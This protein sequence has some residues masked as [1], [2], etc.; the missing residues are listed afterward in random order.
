VKNGFQ[1]IAWH[2]ED[3]I[4][5]LEL[6]QPPSNHMTTRFFD[7][8]AAI[9]GLVEKSKEL[10][11][12]VIAGTGRHYSSGA[13]LGELL[14][15]ICSKGCGEP[16]AV[17][18]SQGHFLERNYRAFR[19]LENLTIP[20]IS[21]IR[22]VCLGSAMELAMY[23]HFR[24]C[25]EDAVFGLPEATFNLM[26]GMGGIRK[27][28][29]LAGKAKSMEYILTGKTFPAQEALEL[30]IVD[31]I[32]PK[33]KTLEISIDFARSLPEKYNKTLKKMYLLRYKD[34]TRR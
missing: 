32:F 33:R 7:E 11:A 24:F 31:R 17:S 6:N 3:G 27:F 20:V 30:G 26:P 10:K 12:I 1:T 29:E 16:M 15:K 22:G 4:G 8:F 13:N 2:I 5:L 14:D 18:K 19:M 9:S 34:S 25:G 21:A 28:T 23:S